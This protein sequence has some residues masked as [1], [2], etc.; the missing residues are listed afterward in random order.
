MHI[1]QTT[2]PLKFIVSG[3]ALDLFIARVFRL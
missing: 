3:K 2:S 1:M